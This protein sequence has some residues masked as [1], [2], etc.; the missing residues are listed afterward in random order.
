MWWASPRIFI[1]ALSVVRALVLLALITFVAW[2]AVF[3][4]PRAMRSSRRDRGALESFR[5]AR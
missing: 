2:S 3:W 4:R 1:P 5:I